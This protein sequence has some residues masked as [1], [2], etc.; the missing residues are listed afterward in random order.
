MEEHLRSIYDALND[1][2]VRVKKTCLLVVTHLVLN[3]ML[4]IKSDIARI[5]ILVEDNDPKIQSQVKLFFHELNKKD[6]NCIYNYMPDVIAKLSDE[7][8]KEDTF[9]IFAESIFVYIDKE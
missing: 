7:K 2:D 3:D 5:A 9:K 8:V 1:E 6:P 4:R